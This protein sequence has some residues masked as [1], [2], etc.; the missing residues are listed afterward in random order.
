M[1][2]SEANNQLSQRSSGRSNQQANFATT[3]WSVVVAAGDRSS[4]VSREALEQLCRTYWFPLYAFVRRRGYSSHRAEDLTQSFF[5][6]LIEKKTIG[7]ISPQ[8]GRFRSFLLKAIT[9]FLNN[10]HKYESAAKRGG[11]IETWSIDFNEADQQYA[12]Q[13]ID[14]GTADLMFERQWALATLNQAKQLTQRE[15]SD[16][17]DLYLELEPIISGEA[18]ETSY[19]EIADRL[20][21]SLASV[22][23]TVHRLRK[24]FS[25]KLRDVISETVDSPS[26]IDDEIR[27][28]MSVFRK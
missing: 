3:Q 24:R 9:N 1:V 27:Y 6:W 16:K 5:S 7:K 23:V 19:Q 22:K 13:P 8:G 28:L 12:C 18:P 17:P 15:Y 10:E 4:S 20:G 26:E 21:M 25:Q 14:Q 2:N 11:G